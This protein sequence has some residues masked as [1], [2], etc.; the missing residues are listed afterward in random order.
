L[1]VCFG[2]S[3]LSFI[4]HGI[5]LYGWVV[6]ESRMSLVKMGYMAVINLAGAVIYVT[7]VN[8]PFTRETQPLMSLTLSGPGKVASLQVRYMGL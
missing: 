4:C 5:F 1:Y 3:S 7:R 6:Q 2:A 8:I